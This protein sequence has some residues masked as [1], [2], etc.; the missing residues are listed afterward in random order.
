VVLVTGGTGFLGSSLISYLIN[1][2][3]AVLATKRS[4]STIPESLR[5]SSLIQWV[6]ADITDYFALADLFSGISKV[7][8]CAAM[9]SYQKEDWSNMLHTNIEGTRHIV[10]L[11]LEHQVRLVHV[12]SIAALGVSKSGEPIT[13]NSKWDDGEEHS[14]YAL[15]K[16]ESE[17]EVWRG[18]VEGLDAVIVNPSVIMGN[19]VGNKG[20]GVIFSLVQKGLKIY[21]P[22]SVGIVDVADVAKIMIQLMETPS[23]SGE[24]FILNSE[25]LT[26]KSLLERISILLDK[27]APT[28]EAK[29]FMLSIAWRI[30]KAA[31]WFKS[32]RPALT[33]ESAK[34]SASN[35][36]YSN[37]KLIDRTGYLFKPID[38][39]LK[40]M[41]KA[42]KD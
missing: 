14:K 5:S 38:D 40:E 18:I 34:A 4:Q 41:S 29:P 30:A 19:G 21:P 3:V 1:D 17:M 13:E 2:G 35:W 31:A 16:H 15:S 39:T 42:F 8:H 6:D 12:S 23:I 24:R 27:P 32:K 28:I 36:T 37:Q 25:N 11:C 22:G 9:I 10:N 26:N 7:Y 33:R 20:S